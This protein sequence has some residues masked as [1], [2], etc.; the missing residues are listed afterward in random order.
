M[1][2]L[3]SLA[4]LTEQM[5]E[6]EETSGWV[7]WKRGQICPHMNWVFDYFTVSSPAKGRD[8]NYIST[9][10]Y[11]ASYASPLTR[12]WSW[13]N[14]GGCGRGG[15]RLVRECH[16]CHTDYS[17]AF[18][19]VPDYFRG[20]EQ[21]PPRAKGYGGNVCV[22][23]SWKN[24]GTG[25]AIDDEKWRSHNLA[26]PHKIRGGGKAPRQIRGWRY[27]YDY[28]VRTAYEPRN[29]WDRVFSTK[30]IYRPSV[31]QRVLDRLCSDG[32]DFGSSGGHSRIGELCTRTE[33]GREIV[34]D[35]V[36]PEPVN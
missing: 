19:S 36:P 16:Y 10:V 4:E 21:G 7:A 13:T 27:E 5:N 33:G 6:M 23:T 30:F 12:V 26:R 25:L 17:L 2:I 14:K 1:A 11:D 18:V 32:G 8:G 31:D 34:S 3:E 24:L 9:D 35:E 29:R 28:E 20:S 15:G 22:L